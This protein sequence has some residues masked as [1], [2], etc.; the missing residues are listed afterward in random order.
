MASG[1][2]HRR[3]NPGLCKINVYNTLEGLDIKR[4]PHVGK[5]FARKRGATL[6]H[7]KLNA[8]PVEMLHK[9]FLE[10][11]A[12]SLARMRRVHSHY[13]TLVDCLLPFE[14]LRRHAPHTLRAMRVA[15]VLGTFPVRKLFAEFCQ[16]FCRGCGAFGPFVFLPTL[17]RCCDACLGN[18]REFQVARLINIKLNLGITWRMLG[19]LTIVH[20]PRGQYGSPWGNERRHSDKYAGV[21]EAERLGFQLYGRKREREEKASN[22]DQE[23]DGHSQDKTSSNP[24][25]GKTQWDPYYSRVSAWTQSRLFPHKSCAATNLPYWD[26]SSRQTESGVYCTACALHRFCNPRSGPDNEAFTLNTIT[27]HFQ[28]CEFAKGMSPHAPLYYKRVIWEPPIS[29][30]S[31]VFLVNEKGQI[32]SI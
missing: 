1:V 30:T 21:L 8:I 28:Q 2:A 24:I 25:P 12:V 4:Y 19:T 32:A 11:D 23:E 22:D 18:R 31:E 3:K 17:S 16:P 13:R 5:A 26:S 27:Q 15:K 10:L 29:G 14:R 6:S 9:I 7:E 20:C